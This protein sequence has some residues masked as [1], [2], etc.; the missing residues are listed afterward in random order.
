MTSLF[1]NPPNHQKIYETP[2]NIALWDEQR[3]LRVFEAGARYSH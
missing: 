3:V 2:L 1:K